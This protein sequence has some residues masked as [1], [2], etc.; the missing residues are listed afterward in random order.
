MRHI[1]FRL[2]LVSL[3][4]GAG[5][6]ARADVPPPDTLS[7]RT[8]REGDGCDP[9]DR[10]GSDGG[11]KSGTCRKATCTRSDYAGWNR[12]ASAAPP[13]MTYEC[14]KCILGGADAAAGDA[15]SGAPIVAPPTGGSGGGGTAGTGG[16][17]TGGAG[18]GGAGGGAGTGGS[19]QKESSGCSLGRFPGPRALGPW[20]LAG[21]FAAAVWFARRRRR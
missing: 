9:D 16:A 4:I 20:A 11:A 3:L 19:G 2:A 21:G 18:T 1:L 8:A 12:D 5:A 15:A 6:I 14:L 7:C 17:G 10:T 13:V